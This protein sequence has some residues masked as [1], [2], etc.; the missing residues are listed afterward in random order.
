LL[1]IPI[2]TLFYRYVPALSQLKTWEGWAD[3]THGMKQYILR[4][5]PVVEQAMASDSNCVLIG[6]VAHTVNRAALAC[7]IGVGN[8]F[9]QYI[10]T[11]MDMLHI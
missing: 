9:V 2:E 10:D 4:R 1:Y 3:G 6:T 7:S 8:A 11:T 5:L